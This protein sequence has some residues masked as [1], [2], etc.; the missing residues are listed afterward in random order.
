MIKKLLKFYNRNIK[1]KIDLIIFGGCVITLG[2]FYL[3]YLIITCK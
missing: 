1:L 3:L 2:Q